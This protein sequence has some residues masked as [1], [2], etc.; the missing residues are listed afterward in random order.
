MD[1]LPNTQYRHIETHPVAGAL[2]A[3][4]S[5]VD[6]SHDLSDSIM[7][8]IRAALMEHQVIFFR[9]QQITPAQQ[10]AFARRW[11]EIHMHPYVAGLSDHP[12]IIEIKKSEGDKRNFGGTWHTDQ[13]F[14]PRPA[15]ATMLYCRQVPDHGGDT[16]WTNQYLALETLS[17]AMQAM[18]AGLKVV[19]KG[20]GTKKYGG[21]SRREFYG[22][23]LATVAVK[24]PGDLQTTSIHPLLRTHP[25]TGRKSLYVGSHVDTFDGMTEAESAPLIDFLMGHSIRPEFTAR[26]R[27]APE[28]LA[29]WDNRCTM[30]FA[31]N[32]YP[33][34]TRLMHRITIRGDVPV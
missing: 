15:M 9:D 34:G 32:D 23:R 31:I 19:A 18:L 27:W 16:L 3:E 2:G 14:N 11:G 25:E 4:I 20:E 8:E 29:L 5:G 12:E 13:M 28:S 7:A 6:L 1:G 22:E 10:V 26:F 24:D 21:K 33:A 30:H 17:P